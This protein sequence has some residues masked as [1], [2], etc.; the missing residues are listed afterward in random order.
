MNK[1]NHTCTTFSLSA[2]GN[3]SWGSGDLKDHPKKG[4]MLH[5]MM[6]RRRGESAF[7][8]NNIVI[9]YSMAAATRVER[10]QYK[11]ILTPK[12]RLLD[13]LLESSTVVPGTPEDEEEDIGDDAIIRRHDR[14]E[15]DERKRFMG[16]T[17][18]ATGRRTR[19][20][21]S[22][23]RAD[24]SGANTPDPMSPHNPELHESPIT[25]PPSTPAP[26]GEEFSQSLARR[27]TTSLSRKDR[28]LEDLRVTTP[29]FT[30]EDVPVAPWDSRTFPLTDHEYEEMLKDTST[31]DVHMVDA[32]G[33]Q[34]EGSSLVTEWN[35][36]AGISEPDT[37]SL[38]P[39]GLED[40]ADW[41]APIMGM[42]DKGTPRH[43]IVLKLAK[44]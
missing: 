26:M 12:W 9:P 10:L 39:S 36:G 30:V 23:S 32:S 6:R 19:S 13:D 43:S 27:R 16:Y 1:K 41:N 22:D 5:E 3:S 44:R 17:R 25:T 4:G 21:R 35:G 40:S 18:S 8:I 37:L 15:H 34:A 24:S 42:E 14:C 33:H 31:S 38:P 11:E 29:D 2:S 7:D 20:I 28:M